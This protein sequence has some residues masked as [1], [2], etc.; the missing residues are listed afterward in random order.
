MPSRPSSAEEPRGLQQLRR[1]EGG[2]SRK[3]R[4]Q[5]GRREATRK[6]GAIASSAQKRTRPLQ[7]DGGEHSGLVGQLDWD[8]CASVRRHPTWVALQRGSV[9]LRQRQC[10]RGRDRRDGDSA[11]SDGSTRC[12]PASRQPKRACVGDVRTGIILV[13]AVTLF[14]L[15]KQKTRETKSGM[16]RRKDSGRRPTSLCTSATST[17]TWRTSAIRAATSVEHS[18]ARSG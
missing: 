11:A 13:Q 5:R 6:H 16:N 2:G 17:R 7:A 12:R 15:E 14:S 3:P 4:K 10:S 18:A 9:Q 1:H 8:P